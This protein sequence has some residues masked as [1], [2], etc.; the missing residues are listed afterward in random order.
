MADVKPM[1]KA[2]NLAKKGAGASIG[3]RTTRGSPYNIKK[4]DSIN[5]PHESPIS[6][7]VIPHSI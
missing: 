4:K 2:I 3:T 7:S 5:Q 1:R 6:S